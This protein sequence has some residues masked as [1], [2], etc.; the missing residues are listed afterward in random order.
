MLC[1]VTSHVSC[2]ISPYVICDLSLV[3]TSIIRLRHFYYSWHTSTNSILIRWS[4][5]VPVTSSRQFIH[6]R[7]T[8]NKCFE[9]TTT[10][11]RITTTTRADATTEITT[12]SN[13]KIQVLRNKWYEVIIQQQWCW[14]LLAGRTFTPTRRRFGRCDHALVFGL[15]LVLVS[16][17][18]FRCAEKS[19]RR[20][21]PEQ[22]HCRRLYWGGGAFG[23]SADR[24]W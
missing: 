23:R 9:T 12:T 13:K 3:I 24:D 14:L 8:T 7:L 4:C 15:V 22:H 10:A 2:A 16:P 19:A 1:C 5:I 17:I 21:S 6:F 11:T 18:I 20:R